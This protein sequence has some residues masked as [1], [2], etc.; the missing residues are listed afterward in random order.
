MIAPYYSDVRYEAADLHVHMGLVAA[1]HAV[2]ILPDLVQ[3]QR[4]EGLHLVAL[5]GS[6]RREVFTVSRSASAASAP[7]R[8]V[9]DALTA[10]ATPPPPGD[11]SRPV[12]PY[13]L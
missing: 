2:G 11:P 12:S 10:A 5:P 13:I 1:G 4:Y 8:L 3:A 9:R 6:P 7:V